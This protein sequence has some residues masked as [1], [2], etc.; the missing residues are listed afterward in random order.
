[1]P[2]E[3]RLIAQEDN[4]ELA[5]VIRSVL[6][7]HK[8]DKDGTVFTDPTTDDLFQL[9]QKEQS[10]YWVASDD[11]EIIGG[12]GVYPTNGLPLNYAELVKLYVVTRAR[13]KGVGHHLMEL[14]FQSS[15][16]MNYKFLYLE[17]L[18]E[19]G[20]AISLYE[21]KGFKSLSNSLGSSGH[22]A[23]TIW[24]LKEFA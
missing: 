12:C 19:L 8:L 2:I 9:F 20:K 11:G 16:S 13:N 4:R 15:I 23:C 5:A 18:P 17:T 6:K 3:Y 21:R 1:M 10:V 24:M 14:C 22:F 7:E